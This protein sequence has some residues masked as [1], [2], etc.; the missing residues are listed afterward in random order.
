[1]VRV[2]PPRVP[3]LVTDLSKWLNLIACRLADTF[4]AAAT[5]QLLSWADKL[6]LQIVSGHHGSDSVAVAFDA[7]SHVSPGPTIV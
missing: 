6:D 7:Y 1:M 5:E 2:K 4:R 3:N